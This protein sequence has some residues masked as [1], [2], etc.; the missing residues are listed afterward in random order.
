M[1]FILIKKESIERFTFDALNWSF[2]DQFKVSQPNLYQSLSKYKVFLLNFWPIYF[3]KVRFLGRRFDRI[4]GTNGHL[5]K[6]SGIVAVMLPDIISW[7]IR[8]LENILSIRVFEW[9]V[10]LIGCKIYIKVT[11][12]KDLFTLCIQFQKFGWDS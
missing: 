12:R 10:I 4:L 11:K 7:E 8:K 3:M 1:E 6:W 2:V 5:R 9:L